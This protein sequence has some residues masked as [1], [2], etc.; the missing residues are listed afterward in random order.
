MENV[1]MIGNEKSYRKEA[2]MEVMQCKVQAELAL[3][4]THAAA[5]AK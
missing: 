2:V 5:V 4:Q 3:K 1:Q